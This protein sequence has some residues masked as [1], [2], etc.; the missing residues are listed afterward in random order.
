MIRTKELLNFTNSPRTHTVP[1]WRA[2]ERQIIK[3]GT[4]IPGK[5]WNTPTKPSSCRKKPIGN[6]QE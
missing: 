2:T 3:A 6:P 4:S 5:L 1:R